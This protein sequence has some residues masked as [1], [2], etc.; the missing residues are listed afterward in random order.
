MQQVE[1]IV[2][3]CTIFIFLKLFMIQVLQPH[4]SLLNSNVFILIFS[5]FP[6]FQFFAIFLVSCYKLGSPCIHATS[7]YTLV[8]QFVLQIANIFTLLKLLSSACHCYNEMY[9]DNTVSLEAIFSRDQ[10]Q[11]F[12]SLLSLIF[13]VVFSRTKQSQKLKKYQSLMSK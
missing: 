10:Q 2:A 9:F 6:I 12:I 8:L 13:Q 7:H 1:S 11:S 5:L 4:L 3:D